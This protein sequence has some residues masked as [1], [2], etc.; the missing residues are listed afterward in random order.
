MRQGE[1]RFG[2]QVEFD[3]EGPLERVLDRTRTGAGE[4]TEMADGGPDARRKE[5]R[6]S[7]RPRGRNDKTLDR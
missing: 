4:D 7:D 5:N 2:V 1:D 6:I 3:R